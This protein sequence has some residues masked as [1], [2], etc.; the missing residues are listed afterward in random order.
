MTAATILLATHRGAAYLP[1][2]LDSIAGQD[3]ADWRLIASDDGSDD[4]TPAILSGFAAAHPGRV[5]IV[6]G[7]ERGSTANFRHLLSVTAEDDGALAL[8]DQ[9]DVW[10]AHKLA[11]ALAALE[12]APPDRPALYCGR[13]RVVDAGL[14]EIGLTPLPRRPLSF[15][16][17]LVQN[18]AGGNTMVLNRAAAALVRAANAEAGEVPVHDWWIYQLVTGAGGQVIFD[19]RPAILY[20]QHSGNAIGAGTGPGAR[21]RGLGRMWRGDYA[22]WHRLSAAALTASAHRLTAANRTRL[23]DFAAALLAPGPAARLRLLRR[24]GVYRQG[25]LATAAFWAGALAGLV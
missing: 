10:L 25:R 2:Q 4:A 15:A 1:A 6:A 12:Q 21:L 11:R 13:C 17:A 9:D 23:D 8:C 22:R 3:G 16:N 19:D 20:R 7:P 24:A 18:V 14:R 5:R